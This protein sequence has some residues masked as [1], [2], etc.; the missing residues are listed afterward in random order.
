MAIDIIV[1]RGGNQAADL[2]MAEVAPAHCS[3]CRDEDDPDNYLVV[4]LSILPTLVDGERVWQPGWE[5]FSPDSKITI[6]KCTATLAELARPMDV[7]EITDWG[8]ASRRLNDTNAAGAF[9]DI[10]IREYYDK[11]AENGGADYVFLRA[12]IAACRALRLIEEGKL[13]A[14]QQLLYQVG[15]G[16]YAGQDGSMRLKGAYASVLVLLGKLYIAAGRNDVAREALDGAGKMFAAGVKCS[17]EVTAM[18][19]SLKLQ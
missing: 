13:R 16:L 18:F 7:A 6:G 12:N 15:D 3:I 11:N 5:S 10:T 14:A 4:P 1:G 2:L 19:N 8:I 9:L 17:H